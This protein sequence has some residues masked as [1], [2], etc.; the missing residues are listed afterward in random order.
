MSILDFFQSSKVNEMDV[1]I[2]NLE[3][4]LEEKNTEIEQ[5]NQKIH[6][7][8]KQIS[9]LG[10]RMNTI[11]DLSNK[12]AEPGGE[13]GAQY[14]TSQE[15]V[16]SGS[17]GYRYVVHHANENWLETRV[18]TWEMLLESMP[19][20]QSVL[21]M[22]CNIGANLKA[23]RHLR[24]E[25]AISGVEINKPAVDMLLAD[26]FDGVRQGSI[27]DIELD[28][29]FDLVFTRGVLIH[30]NP[31]K[32]EQTMKNMAAHSNK[33]V[34]I[35]EHFDHEVTE[36]EHYSRRVPEKE[37]GQGYQYWRDFSGLF[38]SFH[39]DWEIVREGV[40]MTVDAKPHNKGDMHWTI[41]RRNH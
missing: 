8:L 25:L 26:G 6:A 3:K 31:D 33:Y 12:Q 10:K 21:E 24:P 4:L 15:R 17:H 2:R 32:L 14:E 7:I 36:L 23:L 30:I 34:L 9:K 19:D 38:H 39:P 35:Y 18:P 40:R 41:F 22:G 27:I 29:K 37:A 13:G 20:V 28:Q 1:R 16:W 5:Q 11:I